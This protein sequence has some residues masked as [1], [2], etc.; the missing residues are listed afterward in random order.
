M[1][2]ISNSLGS[3]FKF[4]FLNKN[5]KKTPDDEIGLC[6]RFIYSFFFLSLRNHIKDER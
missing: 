1:K 2:L 5:K 6:N 4:C 3:R